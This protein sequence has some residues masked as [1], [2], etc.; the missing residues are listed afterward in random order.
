MVNEREKIYLSTL[1][2]NPIVSKVQF[3]MKNRPKIVSIKQGILWEDKDIQDDDFLLNSSDPGG[4]R[5]LMRL[6]QTPGW[7]GRR[8]IFVDKNQYMIPTSSSTD[9][10]SKECVSW[11][12][13]TPT[14]KN[15]NI[16]IAVCRTSN[17]SKKVSRKIL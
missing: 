14:F 3:F 4:F 11:T 15:T 10:N 8:L 1:Q 2:K 17:A 6:N 5:M 12:I 9:D 13:E 7:S 16:L